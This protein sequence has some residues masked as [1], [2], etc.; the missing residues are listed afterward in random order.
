M[1]QWLLEHYLLIKAL[2][3]IAVIAWMSGMFYLPRLFV[4]HTETKVGAPDYQRFCT[5]ERRLLKAIMLPSLV[6]VWTFGL[7]MAWLND[8][9]NAGWFQIKLALVAVL[10]WVHIT[11][12]LLARDFA[13]GR[14]VRSGRFFRFW[15]ELPTLLMIAIVILVVTKAF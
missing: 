10:T 13:N 11:N 3:I 14:N 1:T 15:N 6:L 8:W 7:S 12:I 2:H 5:M 9:W 4:Y